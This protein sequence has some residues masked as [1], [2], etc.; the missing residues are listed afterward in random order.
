MT[1]EMTDE[2]K[3]ASKEYTKQKRKLLKA[4]EKLFDCS[5][6]NIDAYTCQIN[7]PTFAQRILTSLS[8]VLDQLDEERTYYKQSRSLGDCRFFLVDNFGRRCSELNSIETVIG[9]LVEGMIT[10]FGH[11]WNILDAV[12][13]VAVPKEIL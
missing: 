11:D 10:D 7:N 2:Q 12:A 9:L 3:Q 5:S 6:G 1:T 4:E 13:V 8:R